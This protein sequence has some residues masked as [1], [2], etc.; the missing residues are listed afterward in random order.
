M[1]KYLSFQELSHCFI[2]GIAA[3]AFLAAVLITTPACAAPSRALHVIAVVKTDE[4][5]GRFDEPAGLFFDE[6]KSRLYVADTVNDRL[7]SFDEDFDYLSE[8]SNQDFS[9]PVDMLVTEDRRFYVL[10]GADA[11]IKLI[12]VKTKVVTPMDIKGLKKVKNPFIPSRFDMDAEGRFYIVDRLNRRIVVV[13]RDWNYLRSLT[14]KSSKL[15]GF[16]DVKVDSRGNVYA[17]DTLGSMVYV[18]DSSGALRVK[19]GS[20]SE[21][22]SH[23]RFPVSLDVDSKGSVYVLDRHAGKI[24]VFNSHGAFQYNLGGPGIIDGL[25]DRPTYLMIDKQDRIF[26]V[27]GKRVQI[28]KDTLE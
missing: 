22:Q 23:F 16:N 28:L 24:L 10:D 4:F 14:V 5:L 7:V 21:S 26:I 2:P 8:L 9:L 1:K 11:R 18:F 20:Y 17:L 6:T 13:D 19:F 3:L 15:K 12:N 27:D 25:L